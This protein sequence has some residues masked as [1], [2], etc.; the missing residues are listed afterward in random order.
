MPVFIY[1]NVETLFHVLFL[2]VD[3]PVSVKI[4]GFLIF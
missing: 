4:W 1:Y 2:E 3:A